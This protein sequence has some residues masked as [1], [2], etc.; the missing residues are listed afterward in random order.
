MNWPKKILCAVPEGVKSKEVFGIFF[1][2]EKQSKKNVFGI[3]YW[4]D[5]SSKNFKN[6]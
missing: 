2:R 4:P 1:D 5:I 6:N 3:Y